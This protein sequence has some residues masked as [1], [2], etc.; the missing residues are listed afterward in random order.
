MTKDEWLDSYIL[1][2]IDPESEYLK[3]L[4]RDTHVNLLRPRMASGHLQGRMLKM[5]VEMIR[6]KQV[7]EIGTYSGYSALCLA[8][9]LKEGAMLHTFEIND[10]Q[11]D[12]TRPWLENSPFA[13]KITF[14]I[15]DALKVVPE[16]GI[17]FDLA[18][19]DGDKR[20]Y[21]EYY[22]MVLEYLSP[23]GYIV[24][25][26]TLWDGHVLETPHPTDLQTIGIKRFNDYVAADKRVEKVILPLRDGLTIIRKV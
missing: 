26:N 11:E 25:D 10:E 15:G 3:A 14:Y 21:V 13:D 4:Y 2:H 7:L 12:F 18:F 17:T 22:E 9:G 1:Q 8:E 5:F 6:P 23:G 24:A 19:V 20:K 16:L